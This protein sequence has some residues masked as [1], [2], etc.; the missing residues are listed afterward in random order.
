MPKP[1]ASMYMWSVRAAPFLASA[2]NFEAVG[3]HE[4]GRVTSI[5]RIDIT[6]PWNSRVDKGARGIGVYED[7][8]VDCYF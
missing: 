6:F 3:E 8:E 4:K 7:R 1:I 2:A 5:F